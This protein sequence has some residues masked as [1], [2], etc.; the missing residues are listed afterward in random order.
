MHYIGKYNS[1]V[2]STWPHLDE[3]AS[4]AVSGKPNVDVDDDDS[5]DYVASSPDVDDDKLIAEKSKFE[6]K[7]I[8]KFRSPIGT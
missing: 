4:S 7:S 8:L 3:V 5:A 2:N 1:E 6:R